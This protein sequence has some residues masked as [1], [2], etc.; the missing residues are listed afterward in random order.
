MAMLIAGPI[1]VICVIVL[2]VVYY[3]WQKKNREKHFQTLKT[4]LMEKYMLSHPEMESTGPCIKDLI[5]MTTSGS[6]SGMKID[7]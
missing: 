2:M 4:P 7:R 1:F 5:E 3:M 6:G